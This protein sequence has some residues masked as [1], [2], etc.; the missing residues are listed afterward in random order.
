MLI[1]AQSVSL[2]NYSTVTNNILLPIFALAVAVMLMF[3]AFH[4]RGN[5]EHI[6]LLIFV[7]AV[8]ALAFCHWHW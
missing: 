1:L 5:Q 8:A 3:G 2:N 6:G 7:A 4:S